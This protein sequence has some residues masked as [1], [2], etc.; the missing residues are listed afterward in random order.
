MSDLP[1]TEKGIEENATPKQRRAALAP[2]IVAAIALVVMFVFALKLLN[3]SQAQV[4][5]GPA[6]DFTLNTYN[7][8]TFTLSKQQGKVVVINFWASWCGPCTGEA[9][10]LNAVYDEYQDRGVVFIGIGYLDNEGDAKAFLQKFGIRYTTGPD[11]GGNIS[12]AYRVK[13]VPETYI[14]DQQGN[15]KAT[16]PL[17][18]TAQQL[19]PILDSL[20][21]S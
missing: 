2:L 6:P 12:R 7:G 1:L 13:G 15:L 16:I 14:V 17:P 18:T 19:R 21:K 20:L 9:P 8:G 5:S 11:D 4:D 10:E 3:D